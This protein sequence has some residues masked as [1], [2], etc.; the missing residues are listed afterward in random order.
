MKIYLAIPYTGNE[1]ESFKTANAAASKVMELGHIPFS[2]ISHTHPIAVQCGLPKDWSFWEQ[3]DRAFIEWCDELWVA[4]FGDYKKS[5]G[6]MAEIEIAG[7]LGKPVVFM[8]TIP[9]TGG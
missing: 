5:K 1:A 2:P 6:V 8:D 7:S 4:G 3:F 9:P